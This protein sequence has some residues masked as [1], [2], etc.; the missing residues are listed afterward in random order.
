[1]FTSANFSSFDEFIRVYIICRK[2]AL[3]KKYLSK[4]FVESSK[5]NNLRQ[6]SILKGVTSSPNFKSI[7]QLFLRLVLVEI[8]WWL[9]ER[10]FAPKT[11]SNWSWKAGKAMQWFVEITLFYHY[12]P[13]YA[14]WSEFH[15]FCPKIDT[16]GKSHLGQR[17]YL[18]HSLILFWIFL[19]TLYH[20]KLV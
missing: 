18:N 7:A 1:M 2:L 3:V 13:L 9:A 11:P 20:L 5:L 15:F 8:S 10:F 19:F 14:F 16:T 12:L 6:N 17:F 4:V